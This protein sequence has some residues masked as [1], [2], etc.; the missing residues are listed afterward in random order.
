[1]VQCFVDKVHLMNLV[2]KIEQIDQIGD[3]PDDKTFLAHWIDTKHEVDG[4]DT[5]CVETVLSAFVIDG[6]DSGSKMRTR[7][8]ITSTQVPT[9]A[10]RCCQTK[11]VRL[12]AA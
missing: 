8:T 4:A 3:D 10:P 11:C 9:P 7:L 6:A 12:L 2:A 5:M 1:M